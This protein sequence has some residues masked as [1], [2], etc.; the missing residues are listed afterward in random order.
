M[1]TFT[2]KSNI[3]GCLNLLFFILLF[4]LTP[5]LE[6]SNIAN[7]QINLN[8]E[9]EVTIC[10]NGEVETVNE[11]CDYGDGNNVGGYS[12]TIDGRQCN[13]DCTWAPYCGDEIVQTIHAEECDDGNNEEDDFCTAECKRVSVVG[14]SGPT[15]SGSN[16]PGSSTPPGNTQV[17]VVG[18]AY[19]RSNVNILKDGTVIGIVAADSKADFTFTTG[20][21]TPGTTTFGIWAEDRLGLRSIALTVTFEVISGST[22]TVSGVF[23]PPT[24][25]LDKT[26]VDRGEIIN[27]TG[28]TVPEVQ[29]ST[30]VNSEHTIIENTISTETG[31]WSMDFDTS[32][33]EEGA[34]TARAMF[35]VT[36]SGLASESSFSQAVSFFVGQ[37]QASVGSAD[38]NLDG[39]IN[40]IDFSILLFHWNTDGGDSDPPADINSNSRVDLADFS[41]MLFNWTG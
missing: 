12:T 31:D 15:G 25:D 11:E 7:A 13:P 32:P 6:F 35:E 37:G 23:L 18:K 8:T 4:L 1:N 39:R 30:E 41:I 36:E 38:L 17:K 21:I 33:L 5:V 34:H 40:L 27:M 16:S 3:L 26:E 14:P 9:L 19:P 29:V 2:P 22:T 24:L 10:G 20:N 28:S